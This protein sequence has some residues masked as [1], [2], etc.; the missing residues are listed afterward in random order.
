MARAVGDGTTITH[1]TTGFNA[2]LV[3]VDSFD[4]SRT[5]VNQTHMGS[6]TIEDYAPGNFLDVTFTVT[7][8]FDPALTTTPIDQ[9]AEVVTIDWAGS[10]DTSVFTAFQTNVS[11][12][13]A[14]GELMQQTASYRATALS[15]APL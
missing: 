9:A 2:N 15:G 3:S 7:Y 14:V 4:V 11:M 12:S 1:A 8:Q 5:E 10:G 13:S 6:T